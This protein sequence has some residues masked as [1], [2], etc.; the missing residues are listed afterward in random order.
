MQHFSF[1]LLYTW[2]KSLETADSACWLFSRGRKFLQDHHQCL[3][4]DAVKFSSTQLP[5]W[6]GREKQWKP[7]NWNYYKLMSFYFLSRQQWCWQ[8]NFGCHF[9]RWCSAQKNELHHCHLAAG[10]VLQIKPDLVTALLLSS[11]LAAAQTCLCH[12]DTRQDSV[13]RA[14]NRLHSM[15]FAAL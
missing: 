6:K 4:R 14:A 3:L 10:W 1:Y 15:R 2:C 13:L 7:W 5:L 12:K 11:K 8:S 9:F